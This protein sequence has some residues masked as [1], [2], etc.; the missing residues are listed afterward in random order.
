MQLHTQGH[1]FG[2]TDIDCT[3]E[4]SEPLPFGWIAS[5]YVLDDAGAVAALSALVRRLRLDIRHT[6]CCV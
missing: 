2:L 4:F 5:H 1:V 6:S 3:P